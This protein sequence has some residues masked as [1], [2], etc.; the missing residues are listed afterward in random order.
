MGGEFR[1]RFLGEVALN[2]AWG[3]LVEEGRRPRYGN[4]DRGGDERNGEAD[5]GGEQEKETTGGREREVGL[6]VDKYRSCRLWETMGKI[7]GRV[8]GIVEKMEMKVHRQ[9][10]LLYGR[11]ISSHGSALYEFGTVMASIR[12]CSQCLRSRYE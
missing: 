3:R 10:C 4:G 7:A 6:L 12:K 8:I 9:A 11:A 2:S 5:G 1:V